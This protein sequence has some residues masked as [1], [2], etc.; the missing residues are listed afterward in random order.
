MHNYT[1]NLYTLFILLTDD[2]Y[3]NGKYNQS[4]NIFSEKFVI[5][6]FQL[7]SLQF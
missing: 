1:L 3:L 6:Q 7:D 5:W 2:F 4:L